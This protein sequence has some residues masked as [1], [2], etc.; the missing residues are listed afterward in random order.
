MIDLLDLRHELHRFPELSGEE[1]VTATRILKYLGE[2]SPT[3]IINNLGGHGVAAIF[4]SGEAGETVLLRCE[5]DALPI[6]E[7]GQPSY[8]STVDGKGHLCGHDGHM[9]IIM[10]VAQRLAKRP[11]ARGRIVLLFQ[12]AEETGVGAPSVLADEKFAAIRPDFAYA[13]H[14]LPGMPLGHIG[15]KSGP[16]CFASEGLKMSF[17]GRTSHASHPEDAITPQNALVELMSTLNSL[18]EQLGIDR[19]KALVTICH[20]RLGLPAFG[21]TPGDGD[22]FAA[23]R[24]ETDEL[25]AKLIA[26]AAQYA[27]HCAEKHGLKITI[28]YNEKFAA[29][30]NDETAVANIR[31][32]AGGLNLPIIDIDKPFRWSED[33][34]AFSAAGKTALFVLGSGENCPQLHAPDYDFPDSIINTGVDMFEQIARKHCG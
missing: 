30:D 27:Q 12:P 11:I 23:F 17:L 16:L 19:Q 9:A 22:L 6:L 31:E 3:Q 8:R 21:I 25:Q 15:L 13:L 28:D 26:S 10:G 20:A 1:S 29:C 7:T 18:P 33:F 34:G 24:A 5:L 14:N 2:C 4:D 32:A